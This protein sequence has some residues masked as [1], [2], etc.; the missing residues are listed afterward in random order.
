[1]LQYRQLRYFV[2]IVEAGSFSRAAATI[3]VAQPALSQQIAHLEEH[4]G[5]DLLLRSA[6]GVRPTAAGAILYREASAILQKMEQLQTIV[7]SS[8]RGAAGAVNIGV[9]STLFASL[10]TGFVARC[11]QELP[12]VK[13]SVS[14]TDSAT[15]KTR[16]ANRELDAGL[17]FEDELTS[18]FE[19]RLLFRQRLF[20]IGPATEK[21]LRKTVT[22]SELAELP[23]ILPARPNITRTALDHVLQAAGV[24]PNVAFEADILS[25]MLDAVRSGLG[26]TV[27]PKSILTDVGDHGLGMPQLIEPQAFVSCTIITSNNA[28]GMVAT[29]SVC[30]LLADF[31]GDHIRERAYSGTTW[32]AQK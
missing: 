10:T 20:L 23:L 24:V 17:V 29:Q 6:R 27:L 30:D 8:N 12:K 5:V 2:K 1:M 14:V 13:L 22:V 7:S 15:I 26:S 21:P 3:Y 32:I 4:L 16:V 19:R 28:P 18:N 25:N 9:T 31:V 11:K